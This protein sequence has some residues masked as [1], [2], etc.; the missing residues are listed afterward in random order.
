MW[1]DPIGGIATMLKGIMEI[2]FRV[3]DSM[4]I[5]KKSV[6]LA[7]TILVQKF[8]VKQFISKGEIGVEKSGRK[9]ISPK[10]E[11]KIVDKFG[12][13]A[14]SF[15]STL[16]QFIYLLIIGRSQ[17]NCTTSDPTSKSNFEMSFFI[18]NLGHLELE[19]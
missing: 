9:Y 13:Q 8:L 16:F 10:M 19:W 3:L 11:Q 15:V 14:L 17:K 6:P 5:P 1:K 7:D 12:E 18:D 2:Q 4:P